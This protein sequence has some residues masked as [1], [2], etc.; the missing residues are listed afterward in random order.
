[1]ICSL[2]RVEQDTVDVSLLGF[3]IDPKLTWKSHVEAVSSRLA[4]VIFLL[5]KLQRI[6]TT[7]YM[8]TAYHALFHSHLNYG[9]RLW[10]HSPGCTEVLKLQ[11]KAVRI[12]TSSGR[13]D[14][15]MPLFI[16]LRILTVFSQYIL[17]CLS[18][19]KEDYRNYQ[20]R[21][22]IHTHAT[23]SKGNLDIPRCR[24][25][26]TRDSFPSIGL[27]MFN[28]LPGHIQEL[29]NKIFHSKLKDWLVTRPFYS[30]QEFF[31]EDMDIS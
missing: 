24:L 21:E 28:R 31:D 2:S 19:I 25:S 9:L 6:V 4:R 22:E 3:K 5:R 15:C 26:K 29:P 30:I 10:G 1:M 17:H 8:V 14:H 16:R 7:P 18:S 20:R 23:R 27:R 12:I 11:K 13:L